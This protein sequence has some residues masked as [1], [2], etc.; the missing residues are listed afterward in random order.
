MYVHTT[1]RQAVKQAG[2]EAR[3]HR[4]LLFQTIMA[5]MASMRLHHSLHLRYHAHFVTGVPEPRGSQCLSS[6]HYEGKDEEKM[7]RR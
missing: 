1:R 7:K 3:K 2:K 4:Q 5:A 6:G